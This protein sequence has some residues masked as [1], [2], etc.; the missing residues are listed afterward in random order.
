VQVHLLDLK[1]AVQ[2]INVLTCAGCAFTAAVVLPAEPV[3]VAAIFR[4]SQSTAERLHYFS[5][6]EFSFFSTVTLTLSQNPASQF[7][8]NLVAR[9]PDSK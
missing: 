4:I 2:G 1:Q 7:N 6:N 8:S 9:E 5:G 3:S